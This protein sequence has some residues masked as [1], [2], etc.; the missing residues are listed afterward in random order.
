[1]PIFEP[2]IK[3]NPLPGIPSVSKQKNP[4]GSL[5]AIPKSNPSKK[6]EAKGNPLGGFGSKKKGTLFDDNEDD[7][8]VKPK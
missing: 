7:F 8:I 1:M 5:P 6:N 2:K 4:L 3:K